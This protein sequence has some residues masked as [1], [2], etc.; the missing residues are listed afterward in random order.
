M[1]CGHRT[2][3]SCTFSSISRSPSPTPVSAR[4]SSTVV[5]LDH[6]LFARYS[7]SSSQIEPLKGIALT[8]NNFNPLSSFLRFVPPLLR[9]AGCKAHE[10]VARTWLNSESGL[11]WIENVTNNRKQNKAIPHVTPEQISED[12]MLSVKEIKALWTSISSVVH[13]DH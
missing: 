3:R 5:S 13:P 9:A 4:V 8:A 7:P 1:P 2:S 6:G 12:L 11:Q 10:A